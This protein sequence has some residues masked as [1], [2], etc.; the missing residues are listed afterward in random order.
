MRKLIIFC[1]IFVGLS[2]LFVSCT[3]NKQGNSQINNRL[4][5]EIVDEI[6]KMKLGLP[7]Q[8]PNTPMAIDGVSIDGDIIEFVATVPNSLFEDIMVFGTDA[9]N[10]D[11]NIA[12]MINNINPKQLDLFIKAGFG[13]RNIYKSTDT[14][15]TLMTIEASCQRLKKVKDGFES[16]EIE[17]YTA[18]EIFQMELDKY[19]FPCEIEEGV[20]MTDGYIKGNTVYYIATLESDITSDDLSYTDI[21]EMKQGI[22][23]GF[24]E[25]M[26]S[27]HKKEM[28]QK[29]IRIIYV[30]KN[31]NGDEFARVEITADDL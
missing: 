16:G 14:G 20:W 29:G 23:E 2:L 1:F 4:R 18:L 24:K 3:S 8:I 17:P 10:S 5:Q 6:E 30:Y 22:L 19:E 21:L 13:I 11:K 15:E 28:A 9:A 7:L 25:S 27:V 12:R 31:N 26:A